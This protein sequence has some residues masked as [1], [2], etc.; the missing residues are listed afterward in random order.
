MKYYLV[1][2][3]IK[4]KKFIN[5]YIREIKAIYFIAEDEQVV[6]NYINNQHLDSNGAYDYTI[7]ECEKKDLDGVY[8]TDGFQSVVRVLEDNVIGKIDASS[9]EFLVSWEKRE[10]DGEY[11]K[12]LKKVEFIVYARSH[13]DAGEKADAYA[14]SHRF[15]YYDDVTHYYVT[16]NEEDIEWAKKNEK[17][18]CV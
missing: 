6:S 14:Y 15:A 5:P 1:T 18:V 10:H 16:D 17:V 12:V 3:T 9:R 2:F 7:V 8:Y 11:A 4:D 13:R